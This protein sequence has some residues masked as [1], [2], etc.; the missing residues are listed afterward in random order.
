[1]ERSDVKQTY[2]QVIDDLRRSAVAAR[3]Q[4]NVTPLALHL[5]VLAAIREKILPQVRRAGR[6][7]AWIPG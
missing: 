4:L 5:E 3:R 1:M 7:R 6:S 2:L